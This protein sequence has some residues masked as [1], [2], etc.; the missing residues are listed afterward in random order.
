[1]DLKPHHLYYIATSDGKNGANVLGSSVER[2]AQFRADAFGSPFGIH[3]RKG[4]SALL[5][6]RPRYTDLELRDAGHV[7][8]SPTERITATEKLIDDAR[9]EADR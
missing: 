2:I 6:K 9:A 8:T 4:G 1:M 7:F 5:V 3:E